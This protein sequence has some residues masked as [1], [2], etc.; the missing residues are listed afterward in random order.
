MT[1]SRW[2]PVILSK[3]AFTYTMRGPGGSTDAA[4]VTIMMSWTHSKTV[5]NETF[6]VFTL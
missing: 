2:Y 6:A 1:S 3:A 5:W 4:S